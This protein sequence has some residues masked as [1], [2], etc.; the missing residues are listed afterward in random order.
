MS[1]LEIATSLTQYTSHLHDFYP[2]FFFWF[3]CFNFIDGGMQEFDVNV[4]AR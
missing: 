1:I 3:Q 4:F 2:D